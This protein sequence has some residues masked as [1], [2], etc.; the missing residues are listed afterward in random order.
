MATPPSRRPN[1]PRISASASGRWMMMNRPPAQ[2]RANEATNPGL[3]GRGAG[4]RRGGE[5]M[6]ARPPGVRR[7]A[8]AASVKEWR[9]GDDEISGGVRQPRRAPFGGP[10]DVDARDAGA[11][12]Q[13]I[14]N[15]IFPSDRSE[16]R[17]LFDKVGARLAHP[18]EQR[19]AHRAD[20]RAD[21]D[22]SADPLGGRRRRQQDG[23]AAGAMPLHRLAKGE[24]SAQQRVMARHD[25]ASAFRRVTHDAVRR[26]VPPRVIRAARVRPDRR[27]P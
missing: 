24:T 11:S 22:Q 21:V 10:G 3:Q 9:I 12:L 16:A 5:H 1:A 23:V 6:R 14:E 15:R 25:V 17:I 7:G 8:H 27:R 26:R 13:A 18:L 19:Q 20:A 2:S 4:R